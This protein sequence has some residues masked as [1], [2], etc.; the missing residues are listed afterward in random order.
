MLK[1]GELKSEQLVELLWDKNF[2]FDEIPESDHKRKE[3]IGK[4]IAAINRELNRRA[5]SGER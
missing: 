5:K 3:Q 4:E 1:F 2:K